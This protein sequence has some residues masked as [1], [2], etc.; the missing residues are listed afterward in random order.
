[1]GY[2]TLINKNSLPMGEMMLPKASVA[3]LAPLRM[4]KH[5]RVRAQHSQ[6]E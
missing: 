3:F 4:K 5:H 6:W 2:S 1:L